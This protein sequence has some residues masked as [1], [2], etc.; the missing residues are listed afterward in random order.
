MRHLIILLLLA[1]WC[2]LLGSVSAQS[3]PPATRREFRGVWLCTVH[4]IDWPSKPG[5]STADQKA[6]L[7]ALLDRSRD[8]GLNAIVFQVRPTGDA[9]YPSKTEPWSQWLTG[10]QGKAPSPAWDPLEFAI[11]QSHARGMEL[12]AWINPFRA[13]IVRKGATLAPGHVSKRRPEIVR[14]YG[15]HL[16][17]D[18]GVPA[19]Q[20]YALD[21]IREIAS[22]YDIDGLHIDDYFYPYPIKD[23]ANKL[24]PFPDD[25]SYAAY[26]AGGGSL[27]R[28]DWRRDNINRFVR[29]AGEVLHKARPTA[30]YGISPFGIWKS[31]SVSGVGNSLDAYGTLYKDS[32]LWWREGWVDYMAPQLYW[33]IDSK[34][35]F[36]KLMAWWESENVRQRHLWPGVFTSRVSFDEKEKWSPAEIGNQI[37]LVQ[38][39]RGS[40]G[41]IHFSAR[42]LRRDAGLND[43]LR[44]KAYTEPALVPASPWLDRTTPGMPTA[45]VGSTPAGGRR[46]TWGAAP[47]DR[48]FLFVVKIEQAGRWRTRIVPASERNADLPASPAVSRIAVSAVDRVGNESGPR[49]VVVK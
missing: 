19:A 6:E 16:W 20:D 22:N 48:P 1:A 9:L 17:I 36:P 24:V 14:E 43:L 28:D 3:P 18:P 8:I 38:A 7:L 27:G 5:L 46:A 42:Q 15:E 44:G 34:W 29:R 10:Q 30:R 41:H 23:G 40:T 35:P 21:V 25:K 33:R 39:S 26:K 32:R 31:G 37:A 45:S 13:H 47:G 2:S 12:H 4:N 11:E 49:V